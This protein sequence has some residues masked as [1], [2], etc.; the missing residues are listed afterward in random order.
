MGRGARTR[1]RAAR[2]VQR[3]SRPPGGGTLGGWAFAAGGVNYD[4][5]LME[6]GIA[7]M[8]V[9]AGLGAIAAAIRTR[10]QRAPWTFTTAA[11]ALAVGVLAWPLLDAFGVDVATIAYVMPPC[12]FGALALLLVGKLGEAREAFRR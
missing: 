6:P 5:R 12:L 9:V 1:V 3:V 4:P 11:V 8:L 10:R 2:R 7:A